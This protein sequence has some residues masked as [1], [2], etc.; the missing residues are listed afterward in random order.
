MEEDK[1][2]RTE[3]Q[4]LLEKTEK[5]CNHWK[6]KSLQQG[7]VIQ[8]KEQVR[9]ILHHYHVLLGCTCVVSYTIY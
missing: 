5:E 8:T 6:Q 2:G 1:V 4:Q 7:I 9:C 3:L